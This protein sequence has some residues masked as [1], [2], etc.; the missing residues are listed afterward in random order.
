M[1]TF[2]LLL[3]LLTHRGTGRHHALLFLSSRTDVGE[4]LLG[5][6]FLRE[7]PDLFV[8][9][10]GEGHHVHPEVRS[11][12]GPRYLL[13]GHVRVGIFLRR[14]TECVCVCMCMYI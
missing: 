14:N 10:Q 8:V 12:A 5:Q 4:V 3:L 13:E 11:L 9:Y 7:L 2:F 6:T 1:V